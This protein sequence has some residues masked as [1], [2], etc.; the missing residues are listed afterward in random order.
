MNC[1]LEKL[2]GRTIFVTGATG[3]IGSSLIKWLIKRN[4]TLKNPVK[5][6]ALVRSQ[7]RAKKILGEN[8]QLSFITGDVLN[9]IE[10]K[11]QIDFVVHAA[12][13]TSSKAFV[14][15]PVETIMTA[16]MGTRNILELAKAKQ[17]RSVVYLSTMEIYG[18]PDTDEKIREDHAT[19][20]DTMAVRSSYPESKRACESLCCAYEKEY[21]VPVKVVR[22][23]QTFG[24]G[25]KYQDER[26]F[27]EF[28]RCVIEN[29]DI[30]LHTQGRTKRNYL[31]IEDAITAILTVLLE[32]KNGQAYNAANENTYCTIYEMAQLV[33]KQ[34]ADSK[35]KV[36][37]NEV[38]EAKFGFAP[39]LKMNLETSKLRSLG[40]EPEVN[41]ED[42]YRYLVGYLRENG[43]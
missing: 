37:V 17:A 27:A 29:K 20:L 39:T 38:D 16:F 10:I 42:M 41:L 30:V 1:K 26:V 2:Q 8:P 15:E 5:I 43:E 12:S 21:G 35:I 32:G 40:W 36:R 7:E 3:L 33:A 4:R 28:A 18:M 19:N 11:Q 22:L 25:V 24:P 23:A 14:Q 13:Q 34:I 9:Y 6:L 31:Y